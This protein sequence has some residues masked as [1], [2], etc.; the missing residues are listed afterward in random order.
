MYNQSLRLCTLTKV[1]IFKSLCFFIPPVFSGKKWAKPILAPYYSS[2]ICWYEFTILCILL[3]FVVVIW[4]RFLMIIL[5]VCLPLS[6]NWW[7]CFKWSYLLSYFVT[8][9]DWACCWM[10]FLLHVQRKICLFIYTCIFIS[11][12]KEWVNWYL[13]INGCSSIFIFE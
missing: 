1:W 5:V 4:I 2:P 9:T 11:T 13:V 12:C 6:V 7:M 8:A 10:S 3:I